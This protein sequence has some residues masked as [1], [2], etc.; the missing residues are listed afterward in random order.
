MIAPHSVLVTSLQQ[1][2]LK[3]LALRETALFLGLLFLGFVV[4]PIPIY[5]V[6]QALLG[7]FGGDGYGDF[8]GTLSAR[9]RSGDGVA[10]FFVLS[11]YF[12]WQI[13]RLTIHAW[14]AV[15]KTSD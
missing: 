10:W 8:F 4:V 7:E 11:P 2:P 12:A 13:M 3:Q 9:I 1:N 15:S 5:V 6:G 14:Q